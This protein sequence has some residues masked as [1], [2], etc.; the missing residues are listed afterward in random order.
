M[1]GLGFNGED[2]PPGPDSF[3]V[4]PAVTLDQGDQRRIAGETGVGE[5]VEGMVPGVGGSLVGGGEPDHA[6]TTRANQPS[7]VA[8]IPDRVSTWMMSPF[9]PGRNP[10][11]RVRIRRGWSSGIRTMTWVRVRPSMM[12]S[13]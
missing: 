6:G 4:G 1:E 5:G 3:P 10:P 11:G 8:S 9:S 12:A 7:S 13:V 2:Q